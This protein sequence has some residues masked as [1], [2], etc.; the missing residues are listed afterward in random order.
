MAENN[1][2]SVQTGSPI[3]GG[4]ANANVLP[5]GQPQQVGE[6]VPKAQYDE[7]F[8]KF[9]QQG[10]ELGKHREF[11]DDITPLLE[12][13]NDSPEL[14]KVILDEKFDTNLATAILEGRVTVQE[15]GQVQAAVASVQKELGKQAFNASTPEDIAKM[16]EK[17]VGKVRQEIEHRDE[18][19]SFEKRTSDFIAS[20]S[21]FADYGDSIS[22]WLDDHADIVDVE[23]A[24][25]AVKGKLSADEA[26][27]KTI[28][29]QTELAKEIAQN[30]GGGAGVATH[31]RRDS[32]L[33]DQLI[34]GRANPNVF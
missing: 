32:K 16:V 21:D 7:L 14:A 5:A 4:P 2:G 22:R 15:A 28:E 11:F 3:I 10:N 34:G 8:S 20:T 1:S 31:L 24:Y 30:A 19:R 6:M 29:A 33:I 13:L 17:E 18:M 26:A 27:K 25:Y 12:K 23:T 9:G